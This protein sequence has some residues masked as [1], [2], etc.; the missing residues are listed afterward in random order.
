MNEL[1][2]KLVIDIEIQVYVDV[3]VCKLVIRCLQAF[4]V[5]ETIIY[6]YFDI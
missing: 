3:Q 1:Y 5:K 4:E 6:L 2:A